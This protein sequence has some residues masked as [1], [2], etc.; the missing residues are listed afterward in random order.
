MVKVDKKIKGNKYLRIEG[1]YD[2]HFAYSLSSPMN[3]SF[4]V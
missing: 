4:F 2:M 3:F 1:V